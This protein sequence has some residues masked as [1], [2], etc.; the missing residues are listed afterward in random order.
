MSTAQPG[1]SI[2]AVSYGSGAGAATGTLGGASH[3]TQHSS[4]AAVEPPSILIT[5]EATTELDTTARYVLDSGSENQ[6][7]HSRSLPSMPRERW[8]TT[9]RRVPGQAFVLSRRNQF[10]RMFHRAACKDA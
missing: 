2:R 1:K 6:Q 10:D 4:A 5:L 8:M 7:C 3:D 9:E